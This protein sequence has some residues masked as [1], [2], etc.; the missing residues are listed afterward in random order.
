[1]ARVVIVIAS[2]DGRVLGRFGDS[3]MLAALES[4]P[5]DPALLVE[6]L[7]RLQGWGSI[8]ATTALCLRASAGMIRRRS[9][10][11]DGPILVRRAS[12]TEGLALRRLR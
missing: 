10:L 11:L 4:G 3:R 9:A 5:W 2:T 8:P 1:M 12:A 6:E 7:D